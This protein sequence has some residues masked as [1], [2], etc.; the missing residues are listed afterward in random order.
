MSS[1]CPGAERPH[2]RL[3]TAFRQAAA[4]AAWMAERLTHRSSPVHE[5]PAAWVRCCAKCMELVSMHGLQVTGVA[6]AATMVLFAA[7]R[8]GHLPTPP[9][10]LDHFSSALASACFCYLYLMV[11]DKESALLASACPGPDPT[12]P[13]PAVGLRPSSTNQPTQPQPPTPLS[14]PTTH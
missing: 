12:S 1:F 6:P 7:Q 13:T 4:E 10:F 2:P 3:G 11:S 8:P 5:D 14:R 9:S